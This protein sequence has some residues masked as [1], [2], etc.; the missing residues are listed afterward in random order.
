MQ[1][2]VRSR[3]FWLL[4]LLGHSLGEQPL[5]FLGTV[6]A[7]PRNLPQECC[8]FFIL[9][10]GSGTEQGLL[11]SIGKR[12]V[13]LGVLYQCGVHLWVYLLRWRFRLTAFG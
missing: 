1:S 10:H 12:L 6:L 8:Q 9:T 13:P 2:I 7:F 5:G 4:L 3:H 11:S